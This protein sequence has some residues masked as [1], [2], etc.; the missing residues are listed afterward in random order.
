MND[1]SRLRVKQCDILRVKKALVKS[2]CCVTYYTI[3]RPVNTIK[4]RVNLQYTYRHS[5]HLTE[6]TVLLLER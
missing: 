6:K 4:T 3:G 1:I 5:P 2:V